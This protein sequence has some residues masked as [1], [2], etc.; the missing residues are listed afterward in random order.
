MIKRTPVKPDDMDTGVKVKTS[1]GSNVASIELVDTANSY[2]SLRVLAKMTYVASPSGISI[3]K[4]SN[5]EPF[6]G[7]VSLLTLSAWS[8]KDGWVQE[9]ENHRKSIEQ[10]ILKKLGNEQVKA[11]SE[12]LVRI[13]S[14]REKLYNTILDEEVK[15]NSLEGVAN[16]L[17][18]LEQ[19]MLTSRTTAANI[20]SSSITDEEVDRVQGPKSNYPV[21]SIREAAK[22]LIRAEQNQRNKNGKEKK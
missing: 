4:L 17:I 16:A 2:D 1:K 5:R 9:R 10:A 3:E 19:F 21:E 18:K 7:N 6:K 12:Q 22:A 13:H 20:F 8:A 11:I 15:A 14:V